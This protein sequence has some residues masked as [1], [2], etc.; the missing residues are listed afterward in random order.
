MSWEEELF[1]L[2]D[3]LESQ[4]SA[5]YA[6]D[7]EAEIADRSRAEYQQVALAGRLMASVGR[8]VALDVRGVGLL[9]GSIER[10]ASGWLLLASTGGQDWIVR[11]A[12]IASVAGASERA[13]PA[14]AWEAVA[15][16]GI[17]S[18]LR[19]LAESGER[20]LLHLL[21]RSR[22]DGVLRRVGADFVEVV[23]D[24]GRLWL[25]AFSALAAV[26][27]RED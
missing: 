22:Y 25:V 18:A 11:E 14:V 6:A 1:A 26:Q 19:R 7:R 2:F 27:S 24:A 12:A 9:Q 20:C 10:V 8:A 17:G 16:L 15:R 23:D 21:D 3:D 13:V 4:A 5:A